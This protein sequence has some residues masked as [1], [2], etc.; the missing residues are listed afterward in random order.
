MKRAVSQAELTV[1]LPIFAQVVL[2]GGDRHLAANMGGFRVLVA[3]VKRMRIEDY[4]VQAMLQRDIAWLNP[5]HEDNYYIAAATLPWYGQLDAAR[6]VLQ[7]A[8]RIRINDWQPLFFLGFHYFHFLQNPAKG[9]ALLI[10]AVPR[11]RI[12]QDRWA[13]QL[14]A[15]RWMEGGYDTRTAANIVDGMA[16]NVSGAV[17]QYLRVRAD[18]LHALANLQ[19][20]AVVFYE[21]HGKKLAHIEDL[22]KAGLIE[23]IPADPFGQGFGVDESGQPIFGSQ[24]G[25]S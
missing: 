24:P 19:D 4:V 6:Y 11:A 3:D 2:A 23:S 8:S 17:R 21:R 7:Q 13:L 15:A 25:G 22:V 16:E 5:A 1:S 20:L 10:E 14:V 18:R 9:A 12:E